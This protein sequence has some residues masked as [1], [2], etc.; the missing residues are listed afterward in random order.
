VAGHEY[1]RSNTGASI[2]G[3]N[4]GNGALP[5]RDSEYD[6]DKNNEANERRN[7]VR[8]VQSHSLWQLRSHLRFSKRWLSSTVG[9][10]PP[11]I[12]CATGAT[13]LQGYPLH[14]CHRRSQCRGP[15]KPSTSSQF[16]SQRPICWPADAFP[17]CMVSPLARLPAIADLFVIILNGHLCWK[18]DCRVLG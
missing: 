5:T 12:C 14:Q 17:I 15:P 7:S 10:P 6:D 1:A 2:T 11:E 18:S 3:K 16:H 13:L 4:S 9:G 8:F